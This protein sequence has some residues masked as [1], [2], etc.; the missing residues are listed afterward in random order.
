LKSLYRMKP[1]DFRESVEKTDLLGSQDYTSI[2][3]LDDEM[4]RK[5]LCK[6]VQ[7]QM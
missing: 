4:R 6:W 2:S 7:F 1:K 5:F 3:Q